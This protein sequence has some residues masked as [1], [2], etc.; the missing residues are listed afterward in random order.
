VDVSF[1]FVRS[2]DGMG[3]NGLDGVWLVD[4]YVQGIS[5]VARFGLEG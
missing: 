3:R 4:V 1:G 5:F 2:L